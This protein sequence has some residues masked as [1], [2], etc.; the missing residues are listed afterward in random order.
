[1]FS[2]SLVAIVTPMFP[3][4]GLDLDRLRAL[5]DWHVAEGTEGIVIVG[6]TGESPT[7]DYEEHCLLIRTAVEHAGKRVPVIAGTGANST[8]EAVELTRYAKEVGAAAGLSV[9]PY[10]NKPTQEGLYRHFRTIAEAVDI[11]LVLYN[12]PSR[13]IADLSNDTTV[14]LAQVPGIV[15]IKDATGDLFRT[16]DLVRRVPPGFCILSGDDA[17]A[18]AAMLGGMHGVISVVTNVAPRPMRALC[19]AA[20]AGRAAEAREYNDRLLG[21]HRNL[22]IEANPIP[23]K[24]AM[25]QMGLI[26]SGIRLPLTQLSTGCHAAVLAAMQQAGIEV[27]KGRGAGS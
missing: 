5:I 18:M 24:W 10:Y 22:F 2:G 25:E 4:G 17:T 26:E 27:A 13:T 14:R 19:D 1:M 23:V 15:G 8:S 21:L 9:V 6:T 7:V 16:S 3:D 12:V 11:P 20:R